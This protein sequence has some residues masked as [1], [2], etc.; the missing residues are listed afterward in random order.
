MDALLKVALAGTGQAGGELPPPGTPAEGLARAAEGRSA[1]RRLLL[2]AGARA[3][4]RQ[5]GT[6]AGTWYAPPAAPADPTQECS[7]GATRLL[8]AMLG[9]EQRELLP[10]ALDR[11]AR[12]GRCLPPALLPDALAVGT[13][14]SALRPALL[15]TIG[16]RGRWLAAHQRRWDW[17]TSRP[18]AADAPPRDDA[19][20][21]WEEGTSAERLATLRQVRRYDPARGRAMLEAAWKG[22]MADFRAEAVKA[23]ATGL[24]PDD[25]PFLEGALDDRSQH[26][27]AEAA[28]LLARLPDSALAGRMRARADTM[29][30]AFQVARQNPLRALTAVFGAQ[31]SA[32]RLAIVAPP[33]Y[34]RAWLRDGIAERPPPETGAEAWWLRQILALVPPAHWS[35]RFAAAPAPLIAA[36]A[37]HDLAEALLGG[38]ESAT[39]ACRDEAWAAALWSYWGPAKLDRMRQDEIGRLMGDL[40]GCLSPERAEGLALEALAMATVADRR[41]LATLERLPRPWSARFGSAI[42]RQIAE[43]VREVRK[44]GGNAHYDDFWLNSLT[45]VALGLPEGS[46]PEALAVLDEYAAEGQAAV[47]TWW[48]RRLAECRA[49]I[50]TR[51]QLQEVIPL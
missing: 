29:V 33:T 44:E 38:W 41:W 36:A 27:R 14:A 7:P 37:R 34:D 5:A 16:A 26:V 32:D 8:A 13:G 47:G 3:I 2:A 35:E 12:A 24:A 40:L 30:L 46:F 1:E 42:V 17:A 31:K 19:E 18:V 15:A 45:T 9:G 39:L 49:L 25:E 11:L 50:D 21:I 10:E 6:L 43:S 4:Y 22:E 28:Q 20:A 48:P 23:L 51:R